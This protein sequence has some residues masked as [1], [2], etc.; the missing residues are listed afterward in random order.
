[1]VIDNG[2]L[3]YNRSDAVTLAIGISGT[4]NLTQNGAGI[5][6]ITS[7]QSYGTTTIGAGST[8][9][10]GAGVGGGGLGTGA[11]SNSGALVYNLSGAVSVSNV[12]SGTG[13][14]T[15]AGASSG[16]LTLTGVSNYTGATIINSGSTLL[17][18]GSGSIAGSSVANAG[19]FDISGTTSGASVAGLTG[20]GG[21]SL[22]AKTL[23]ITA[24]SGIY[25]GVIHDGGS[26]PNIGG[27]T[28][29]GGT[30]TLSGANTYTGVTTIA[31]GA[32]L[33]IGAGGTTGNLGTGAVTDNGTL[34][35]N[36]TDTAA[37]V[38]NVIS[39]SG[40]L[41]INSG[42]VTLQ[43]ANNY[44]GATS[45]ATG[46]TLALSGS[47]GIAGSSVADTGTFDISGITP[48]GG[49][50]IV[51]L[52]GAGTVALGGKILTLTAASGTFSGVIQNGGIVAGSGRLTVNGGSETLTGT[53]TYT[54]LTTIGVGTLALSGS[55]SIAASIDVIDSGTFDI[56]QTTA[57]AS[58]KALEGIGTVALGG[59]TLT[60]TA[61]GGDLFTGSIQDGGIG[62]GT[63]GGLTLSGGTE[64]LTGTNSY[65]GTTTIASGAT[66]QFGNNGTT[67]NLPSGS[68]V[69][70]NGTLRFNRSDAVT[71]GNVISGSG[72]LLQ[73]GSG[74]L[75]LTAANTYTGA[76]TINTSRT[77]ALSGGGSLAASAVTLSTAS[78]FDISQTTGTSVKNLNGAGSVAL[79]AQTLT[80]TADGGA[81]FIGVLQD[82]GIGGGTGGGLTVNG[83]AMSLGGANTYT[84]VTTIGSDAILLI[85]DGGR[86]GS[87]A[88]VDNGVLEY[89]RSGGQAQTVAN[90]VSGTGGITQLGAGV[91]TLTAANTYTGATTIGA[92]ETLA[93]T[94][95][96]SI[97]NSAVADNGTFDISGVTP[98]AGAT[99]AGL[100][101]SGT[102]ALGTKNLIIAA[103]SGTFGGSFTG[104]GALELA[105]G[106][107]TFSTTQTS[108]ILIDS[109][110][111]LQIGNG[112]TTGAVTGTITDNGT[113]AYNRSDAVTIATAI[114][115]TGG[116]TQAGSG[117]LTITAAQT[118]PGA[119]TINAGT[120][121]ALTGTG[122]IASSA[123]TDN[124]TFDI[125]AVAPAASVSIAGLS[126]S[127][128][129]T[130]GAENL[131]LTNGGTFK[132]VISGSG[133]VTF[134]G[135]T[136]ILDAVET[137]TGTTNVTGGILEVGDN[138]TPT[139][140]LAGGVKVASGGT[141]MGHG[142]ING[143]V[144]IASGG[145]LRPGGTIGTLT[146]NGAASIPAGA[147]F[148]NEFSNTATSKL[149]ASGPVTL[150]GALQL[151][152][153]STT[154]TSGTDYK[155]ITG[156]AVTGTFS[157]TSGTVS[158]YT[159]TIQYSATAVD[160][161]LTA[162]AAAPV[163]TTP[164]V[165]TTTTTTPATATTPAVTTTTTT[166][167][168]TT[169][170][171]TTTTTAVTTTTTTPATGATPAVTTAPVTT[172]T[173]VVTGPPAA[174]T[175]LFNSYGK[176]GNQAAVGAALTASSP[177][178]PLY[179]ALGGIV[180]SNVAGVPAALAQL[181]GDI[182]ASLRSAAIED[183][184]IIRDAVLDHLNKNTGEGI[185]AWGAG[186]GGYGSLTTNGNAASLHHDSAGF[187]AGADLNVG[188]GLRVGL[189]GAYSGNSASTFGKLSSASG[190]SGHV[191]GYGNW[192]GDWAGNRIDLKLG[193]DFGWGNTN[194][195]RTVTALAQT[196]SDSQNLRTSQVFAEGGYRLQTA[197]A[198]VE[199]YLGIAGIWAKTGAF[200]ETG[201]TSALSGG[202]V[203]DQ[204][205]YSTLGLRAALAPVQSLYGLTP[206]VDMGWQY[207]FNTLRPGQTLAFQTLSQSFTVLGVPLSR[208]AAATRAG[209]DI[210]LAPQAMVSLDY[211]GSFAGRVQ[212]NAI[213]G[214]LA[215]KF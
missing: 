9:Q 70:D 32:T 150:G 193:G 71:V 78:V 72:A 160:L 168:A 66:L 58:I 88:V 83:G 65:T 195:S 2:T 134:S 77:L 130:L 214:S 1:M 23:T 74:T 84:G 3:I 125:S 122:S 104:T 61:S 131:I 213:R 56:S 43:S 80:L 147:T 31:P 128:T 180:A 92:G 165:T 44:T 62:G 206:H 53:N 91:I 175:Y 48:T 181:S 16:S 166:T 112:G 140:S 210:P 172:T 117:I 202:A 67:G 99:I 27:L 136:T 139:A 204:Q 68:A 89:V 151:V 59:Q 14:L 194:V 158:G 55:G 127:G 138:A 94:G 135:G 95:V 164:V 190:N 192:S 173:T 176:T 69:I 24:A 105:G 60:L 4:G 100:S 86:L 38:A 52:T 114:T 215:W 96:G 13:T 197:L 46:T 93:L 152:S 106:T 183:S 10:I 177:T 119:T 5:L 169:P 39:G 57:G 137:Y 54:G 124:G 200:A 51:S 85:G 188:H 155:F 12:I 170:A 141:L 107:T 97:A 115:G 179:L 167:V 41:A 34:Q 162:P 212:N 149:V 196:D 30:E 198:T 11:V 22:G 211:D 126:G 154:Y 42:T 73:N 189:A 144:V 40:K 142:T 8:L 121:L 201:G 145:T 18:S 171:A 109:G 129:V 64:Y 19:T 146:V 50:S 205:T 37:T 17:L 187:I 76:T 103:G 118:Y 116:L 153:D 161:I 35:Y 120:T 148:T 82:G 81:T 108:N 199:P 182:H 185:V 191:I 178:S 6:T 29:S 15:Q 33:Q 63:G 21:V 25:S 208:N 28:I 184:R 87:G 207:G 159:N 7:A 49:A 132:G 20:A 157:S 163:V 186:F 133:G 203:T 45:V 111:T 110:A 113:L 75:T 174:V 123:V 90:V 101:G 36:R 156:S 209:F 143:A 79:G 102:V 47:G 98:A 26:F